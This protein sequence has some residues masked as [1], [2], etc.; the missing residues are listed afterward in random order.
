MRKKIELLAPCGNMESLIAAVQNGCD[1]VYLAGKRFGARAFSHNFS[2]EELIEAIQYAHEYGVKV[3]LTVNTIIHEE[4]MEDLISF[5]GFAYVNDIDAIIVQDYGVLEVARKMYPDL[6]IHASTQMHIHN[7]E[8]AKFIVSQ[9]VHRVVMA[10]ETPI[11]IIKQVAINENIEVEA[12]VHGALCFCYSGQCLMSKTLGSRSGNKGE[13]AQPCRLPYDL[14]QQDKRL[15]TEGAYLM[16][17]KDLFTIEHIGDLIDSGITSFKIEGRMKR[18]EYVGYMVSLYRLAIDTYLSTGSFD[19][20][21]VQKE[22]AMK[23]FNRGFTKGFLFEQYG[24]DFIQTN[25]GNHIGIEIGKVVKAY[26]DT[27]EVLLTRPLKQGDGVRFLNEND[28]GFIV[29]FLYKNNLLVSGALENEVVTLKKKGYLEVGTPIVKTSDVEDLQTI[30]ESYRKNHRRIMTHIKLVA[31]IGEPLKIELSDNHQFIEVFGKSVE[32]AKSSPM[33]KDSIAKQLSKTNDTIYTIEKMDI[34]LNGSVFISIKELNQ[35][36]REAFDT[37]KQKRQKH[38]TNRTI[39]HYVC[40]LVKY[41]PLSQ[42]IAIIENE[43]QLESLK[44]LGFKFYSSDNKLSNQ[45]IG[46]AL[47][48]INESGVYPKAHDCILGEIGAVQSYTHKIADASLNVS[49]S[50]AVAFLNQIGFNAV[51]LSLE[52][53]D[54]TIQMIYKNFK[55]R[56]HFHPNLI[57]EVY[58]YVQMMASKHCI[59]NTEILNN[60]KSNCQLCKIQAYYLQ[61]RKQNKFRLLGD[62]NCIMRVFS[63][64]AYFNRSLKNITNLYRFTIE[65]TEEI[66]DIIKKINKQA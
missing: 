59:V 63:H 20:K 66:S 24:K 1:A 3:Y 39:K 26:K 49:N 2:D 28:E 42:E 62:D 8:A 30:Q 56:Y 16:S 40:D 33:T 37:L 41:E 47:N 46:Y 29:N 58:G 51:V 19:L 9:G 61:D 43:S 32:Q 48:R 4:E 21:Q 35:L 13:C 17:T 27:C 12:F 23:L 65:G 53:E 50:Y 5:L 60:N 57:K 22:T 54:Q 6:E 31:T 34:E 52:I 45:T 38:Y 15:N 10:R 36:R 55:E 64:K 11:S 44:Q 7:T 25:R 14:Y 18:P